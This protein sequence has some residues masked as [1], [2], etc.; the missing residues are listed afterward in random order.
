MFISIRKNSAIR[1]S[2]LSCLSPSVPMMAYLVRLCQLPFTFL[3][4]LPL[5]NHFAKFLGSNAVENQNSNSFIL[6]PDFLELVS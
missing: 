3:Y 1:H 5:P 6:C 4:K 2:L